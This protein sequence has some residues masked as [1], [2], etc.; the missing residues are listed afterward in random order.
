MVIVFF[1]VKNKQKSCFYKHIFLLAN[2]R[3][4]IIIEI[5]FFIQ[6]IYK[7]TMLIAISN[8]KFILLLKYF[9]L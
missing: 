6:V 8:K 3:M 7:L 5:L 4:N 9:E 2:I 1:S